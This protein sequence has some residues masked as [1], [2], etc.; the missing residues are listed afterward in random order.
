[1]ARSFLGA[2]EQA[3]KAAARERARAQR[4]AERAH[5]AAV[6]HAEQTRKAEERAANQAARAAQ[7]DRKRMAK[8]AKAAH[9]AARQAQVDRLNAE[10]TEINDEIDS[11]LSW[12]LEFDDHVDLESLRTTA[13]HPTFDRLDLEAPIPAPE[14]K[15]NPPEPYLRRIHP[16]T[17]LRSLFGKKKHERAVAEAK[18]RHENAVAAWHD[19][20]ARLKAEHEAALEEHRQKEAQR[21]EELHAERDR[22]EAECAEREAEAAEHN[23]EVDKFIADLGY[24]TA[25]AVQEY[26]SIVLANSVYPKHFPTTHEFTFHPGAAELSLKVLIPPPDKIPDIKA[27]KYVKTS[28]ETTST[29]LTQKASRERY[30]GAVHQVALRSLHEVFEADR[31]GLI[32]TISLE[33]GTETLDPATGKETYFPLVATGS[34]R[35]S[36]LE[37]DL[38]AVVP[39]ATLNLLGAAISKNPWG[40]V[41]ADTSGIRRS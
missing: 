17:G 13:K 40:L 8:E 6:R 1:M 33:V 39:L 35:E 41:P 10:I 31:R 26:V 23:A 36:F 5:K 22:Y 7:A 38:S 28:D 19:E 12:T 2:L 14:A 3:A 32:Q 29:K 30:A 9:V 25:E 20:I 18:A 34:E 21:E 15:P 16:P 24:G 11:L 27:H 37:I 4:E